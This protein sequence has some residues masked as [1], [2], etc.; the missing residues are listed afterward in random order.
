MS[1]HVRLGDR[2]II[3]KS[4]AGNE[5]KIVHVLRRIGYV[6][7]EPFL[8]YGHVAYFEATGDTLW[9]IESEGL[10]FAFVDHDGTRGTR[11]V[12]PFPDS[13]LRPL[14]KMPEFQKEELADA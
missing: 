5:G 7:K 4:E 8:Y 1:T 12:I 2:A 6:P 11:L 9:E 3:I 13:W 10:P 14:P